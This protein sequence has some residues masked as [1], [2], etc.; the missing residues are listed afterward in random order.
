M[1]P[2]PQ[3]GADASRADVSK[4]FAQ[5]Q[6]SDCNIFLISIQHRTKAQIALEEVRERLR[7]GQLRPGERVRVDDLARELAMSPT[8][9]REAVRLLQADGLLLYRPH[10]G[11]VVTELSSSATE[12]VYCLRLLL[13]P[14]ATKLGV[15]ELSLG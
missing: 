5:R 9:I 3:R 12:E 4:R 14:L 8:P 13:E 1:I 15:A 7:A 6:A 10:H 11:I 2:L